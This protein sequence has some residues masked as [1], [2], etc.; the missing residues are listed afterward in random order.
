[1]SGLEGPIVAWFVSP[2]SQSQCV[3]VSTEQE[4]LRDR[5]HLLSA[6]QVHTRAATMP[7]HVRTVSDILPAVLR[8]LRAEMPVTLR[9]MGVRMAMLRKVR[10]PP[11]CLP[12]PARR[13]GQP[14]RAY[15]ICVHLPCS[16]TEA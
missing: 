5:P 15:E 9:L 8:L 11:G 3:V 13:L 6:L 1:M 16:C 7:R 12:P 4:S 14:S 10:G 2:G